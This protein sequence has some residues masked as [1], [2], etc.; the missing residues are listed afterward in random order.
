[1]TAA[2][3]RGARREQQAADML[4]T[5]R[6]KY[7]G[8][9]ESAPDV[10]PVRLKNGNIL[11]CEVATRARLPQWQLA[12]LAQAERYSPGVPLV[13]LSELRGEPLALLR[14]RDLVRLLGLSDDE[15]PQL[16][17]GGAA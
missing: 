8:R 2:H 1:M 3:R 16:R 4:G 13:V 5:T 11:V 9:F 14:L 17:L 6:T 7:R 15:G 10:T 12:K